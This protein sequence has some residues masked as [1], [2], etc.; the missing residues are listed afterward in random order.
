MGMA[1]MAMRVRSRSH[2]GPKEMMAL[3]NRDLF[4]ELR[5]TAF[6]TGFFGLIDRS[7]RRMAYV[8]AG[9]PPPLL[10]RAAGGCEELDAAGLPFGVDGGP[11][12]E[13]GL[14]EKEVALAPGDILLLYTDGATESGTPE[15]FGVERL[16]QALMSAPLETDAHVILGAVV[17]AFDGFLAGAA[18]GDDVTLVC[19]KI[20]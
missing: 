10:R 8:R 7:S 6:V 18:P 5:R 16:K 4:A 17:A 11:R 20:R 19:L 13:A 2:G 9:H 1:K 14:A 3:A 12:F 15:E